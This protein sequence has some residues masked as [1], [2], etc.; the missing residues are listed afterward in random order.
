[1][2]KVGR[3]SR[4]MPRKN[5]S[6]GKVKLVNIFGYQAKGIGRLGDL[7]ACY[8]RFPAANGGPV[9]VVNRRAG[10]ASMFVEILIEERFSSRPIDRR[11]VPAGGGNHEKSDDH[12]S[13]GEDARDDEIPLWPPDFEET[14]DRLS[15]TAPRSCLEGAIHCERSTAARER[16]KQ[17]NECQKT[18]TYL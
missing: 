13:D 7:R 15:E 12:E 6:H 14:T 8:C 2:A 17:T 3:S 16:S 4:G 9:D 1:M 10:A 5:I 18:C 11:K